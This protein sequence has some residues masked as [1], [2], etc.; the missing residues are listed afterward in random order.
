MLVTC[1]IHLVPFI[2]SS[3]FHEVVLID[4]RIISYNERYIF[5]YI[6]IYIYIYI[7]YTNMD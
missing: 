5:V 7:Y 2:K 1:A 6:Y 4:T 3:F